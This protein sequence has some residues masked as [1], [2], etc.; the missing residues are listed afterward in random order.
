MIQQNWSIN[1]SFNKS[2]DSRPVDCDVIGLKK[3]R[4]INILLQHLTL[5]CW[6]YQAPCWSALDFQKIKFKVWQT[7][8]LVYFNLYFCSLIGSKNQAWYRLKMHFSNL[9]LQ[10]QFSKNQVQINRGKS[11][12]LQ[13]KL[14]FRK[15]KKSLV[16][17][18][19]VHTLHRWPYENKKKCVKTNCLMF[20]LPVLW[21]SDLQCTST[22]VMKYICLYVVGS[23]R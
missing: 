8:V 14:L 9:N 1:T 19:N 21:M 7:G 13:T 12:C 18:S 17:H 20:D 22:N 5:E 10:T 11:L 2:K 15:N 3:C 4:T 16:A 6:C 23:S